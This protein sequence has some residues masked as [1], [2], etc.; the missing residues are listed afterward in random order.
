MWQGCRGER[1]IAVL[2]T[3]SLSKDGKTIAGSCG[4]SVLGGYRQ[5]G[6]QKQKSNCCKVFSSSGKIALFSLTFLQNHISIISSNRPHGQLQCQWYL[7]T[8][9]GI[10][11]LRDIEPT[12]APWVLTKPKYFCQK[13]FLRLI[14]CSNLKA[15]LQD[16]C[17]WRLCL[18][19]NQQNAEWDYPVG[20]LDEK[21]HILYSV[22]ESWENSGVGC[23]PSEL[24][25]SYN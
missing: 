6:P 8:P 13:K 20:G 12:A 1:T 21:K 25:G 14:E 18:Q 7:T 5:C 15:A 19:T 2:S 10:P 11:N 16:F 24:S 22:D 9:L 17:H 23:F 3:T 4:N